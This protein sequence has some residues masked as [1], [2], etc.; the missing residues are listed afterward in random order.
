MD[1][2]RPGD[3][4]WL[5]MQKGVRRLD[6][7]QEFNIPYLGHKVGKEVRDSRDGWGQFRPVAKII[8]HYQV[9]R[10]LFGRQAPHPV[11]NLKGVP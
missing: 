5:L 8:G 10:Q 11:A 9:T 3:V 7:T 6:R 1:L 2:G 4:A